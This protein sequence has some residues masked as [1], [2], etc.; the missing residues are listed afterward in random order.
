[1]HTF[2]VS[3]YLTFKCVHI[4]RAKLNTIVI[5][6]TQILGDKEL[7]KNTNNLNRILEV[8]SEPVVINSTMSNLA[9]ELGNIVSKYALNIKVDNAS[10]SPV[11]AAF[12]TT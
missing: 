1:M 10:S 5:E 4:C 7:F 8:L 11:V 6:D 2:I 3:T 9:D 12:K